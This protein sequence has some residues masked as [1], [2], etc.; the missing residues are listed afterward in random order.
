ILKE[1]GDLICDG[2]AAVPGRPMTLALMEGKPVLNVSGP[3][4]AAYYS[5]DWCVRAMI[6][7]MLTIPFTQRHR[8]RAVLTKDLHSP[9]RMEMFIK[10]NVYRTRHGFR[11]EPV[12]RG[13]SSIADSFNANG[14]LISR[15]GLSF[16]PAGSTV[17]VELEC[18]PD[19]IP[20]VG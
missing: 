18:T 1:K 14:I 16:L 13:V 9:E 20:F 17:R 5:L 4:F 12:E 10:L 15:M 2:V 19:E 6:C 11:A 7:D 8:V 3:P